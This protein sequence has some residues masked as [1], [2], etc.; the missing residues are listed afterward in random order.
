MKLIKDWRYIWRRAW[1][2]RL[3]LISALFSAIETAMSYIASGEPRP[4]V[5]CALL[6]S[7]ATAVSRIVAQETLY[8]DYQNAP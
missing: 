2:V 5:I 7:V 1:S 3:A 8:D 4:F 6:V